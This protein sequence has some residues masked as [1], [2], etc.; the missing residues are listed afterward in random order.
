MKLCLM[1]TK[2]SPCPTVLELD[3]YG[4][5]PMVGNSQTVW[6]LVPSLRGEGWGYLI[7]KMLSWEEKILE[8]CDITRGKRGY[9]VAGKKG[10][11]FE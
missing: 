7:W 6:R 11:G 3:T 4:S 5:L 2:N 9:K 1:L 8:P 10:C